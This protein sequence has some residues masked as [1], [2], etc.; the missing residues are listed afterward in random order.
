MEAPGT[1]WGI[2]VRYLD[3]GEI[4]FRYQ[5]YMFR[6]IWK[7]VQFQDRGGLP[8]VYCFKKSS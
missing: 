2:K 4:V 1:T 7:I 5:I 6:A 8:E 3:S